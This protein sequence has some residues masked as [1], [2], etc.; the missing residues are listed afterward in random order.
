MESPILFCFGDNQNLHCFSLRQKD[1]FYFFN[2]TDQWLDFK[3][4]AVLSSQLLWKF[5]KNP[6][7]KVRMYWHW[8]FMEASGPSSC[9]HFTRPSQHSCQNH[10]CLISANMKDVSFY[11]S[12]AKDLRNRIGKPLLFI[13]KWHNGP[14]V[15]HMKIKQ[16]PDVS[17]P[18]LSK[19]ERPAHLQRLLRDTALLGQPLPK[20]HCWASKT[21]FE[22]FVMVPWEKTE[23]A[24][25]TKQIQPYFK[26]KFMQSKILQGTNPWILNKSD[27]VSL[28]KLYF[29]FSHKGEK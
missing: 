20:L 16:V 13:N 7:G 21:L 14:S 8:F 25:R 18:E 27:I 28:T 1:Y 23:P 22:G 17:Y 3:G 29:Y 26:I 19:Y 5:L 4:M 12:L 15:R 11:N 2:W 10:V 24:L 9:N 6:V